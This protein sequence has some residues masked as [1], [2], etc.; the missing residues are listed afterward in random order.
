VLRSSGVLVWSGGA[1]PGSIDL[2][3][4][5]SVDIEGNRLVIRR[6]KREWHFCRA[7]GGP[8]LEQW[9]AAAVAARKPTG[10]PSSTV[11]RA[12]GDLYDGE[13]SQGKE[14]GRGTSRYASGA[15]Y[16]GEWKSGLR[17]GR[18]TFRYANGDVYAGE[19]RADQRE[20]FGTYSTADGTADVGAYRAGKASRCVRWSGDRRR[21]WWQRDGSV[22]VALSVEEAREVVSKMG[23]AVPPAASA[24]AVFRFAPTSPSASA[25]ADSAARSE[26]ST[27][28]P[29]RWR[30]WGSSWST[31]RAPRT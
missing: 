24:Y 6:A 25:P 19:W 29:R 7:P 12:N 13:V 28:S 5:S 11:R 26:P 22:P 20:G 23:L 10:S 1:Q 16:E 3:S 14:E 15:T 18:G 2:D 9:R 31:P 8:S 4:D 17:E 30:V 21:A 27:P